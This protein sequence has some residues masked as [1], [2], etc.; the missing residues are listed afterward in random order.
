MQDSIEKVI[1]LAAPVSR[2]WRA[3]TDHEEFGQWFRVALDGP[4]RP[5]E[6]SRGQMTYPGCEHMPWLAVVERMEPE[7]LFSFT[8]PVEFDADDPDP[9]PDYEGSARMLVEFRLE[10]TETGTRLTI[11]ESGF[12]AIP[13]PRGLEALRRNSA[14]WDEQAKNIAAHVES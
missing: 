9:D 12:A 14:G 13:D 4:F 10:P 6:I 7:R 3:V 8:W 1:E 5:G 2:V 11:T